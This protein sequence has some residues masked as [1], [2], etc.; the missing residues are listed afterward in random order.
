MWPLQ[1]TPEVPGEEED[2]V[3]QSLLVFVTLTD[4]WAWPG[5]EDQERSAGRAAEP[6]AWRAQKLAVSR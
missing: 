3:L 6:G 1:A 4:I 5:W 2:K